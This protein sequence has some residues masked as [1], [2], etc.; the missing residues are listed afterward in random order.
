MKQP[1]PRARKRAGTPSTGRGAS[2]QV[3]ISRHAGFCF[4]VKRALELVEQAK[5]EQPG[6]WRTLGPLIHNPQVVAK[7]RQQGVKVAASL[8]RTRRGSLIIPSHGTSPDILRQA[9]ERGLQVVDA[10]CPFV[11]K[12]QQVARLLSEQGYRIVMV[13]D[14]GHPEVVGVLSYTEPDP[15]VIEGPQEARSLRRMKRVGLL[16]QTTQTVERLREVAAILVGKCEEL[17]VFNTICGATQQRQAA[18]LELAR[19]AQVMIVV[20]GHN[21]ANTARLREVCASAGVEAH[22]LETPQEVDPAWLADKQRI[23]VTA[24][25]STPQWL[26]E[27][28]VE[29]LQQIAARQT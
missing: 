15:I 29:R 23:G 13:G 5:G 16:V 22:Q 25:A 11:S 19:W 10:T 28:V 12:S 20:G 18:A 24:G 14:R 21:S 1:A 27:G 8:D 4:G 2:K 6:P 3:I 9:Q 17:R 7:L 26:I